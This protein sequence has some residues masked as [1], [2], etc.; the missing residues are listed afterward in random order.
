MLQYRIRITSPK[1]GL[2][3]INSS[4]TNRNM[5]SNH[6]NCTWTFVLSIFCIIPILTRVILFQWRSKFLILT[7]VILLFALGTFLY[8]NLTSQSCLWKCL[9]LTNISSKNSRWNFKQIISLLIQFCSE[10]ISKHTSYDF[11]PHFIVLSSVSIN[12]IIAS[13]SP[14]IFIYCFLFKWLKNKSLGS[15]S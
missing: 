3:R 4:I 9:S 12:I 2:Q 15:L 7:L 10:P 5:H 11:I 8:C 1:L 14:P 6:M 13:Y